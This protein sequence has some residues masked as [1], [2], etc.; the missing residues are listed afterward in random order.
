MLEYRGLKATFEHL[1]IDEAEIDRQIS[2]LIEQ[3]VRT[4]RV[5]NRPSQLDD[6]VVLDFTGEC[7]GAAFEGGHAE[8]YPLLLGS[9]TFIPGFEEQLVGRRAGD[10]VDVNV[11]FPVGYPVASLAGQKA[12]F[13]CHVRE[14]RV[15]EKYRPNDEFARE[16]GGVRSMAE[17]REKIRAELQARVDRQADRELKERLIDQLIE[18]FHPEITAGQLDA[19]LDIEMR[20]L[21]SQLASQNLTLDQYAQFT[22]RTRAQMREDRVPQARKNVWRQMA[23][24]EIV[25]REGIEAD[26]ES[27][28]DAFAA[29]CRDHGM[30][31]EQLQPYFDSQMEAALARSVVEEKALDLLRDCA[32]ITVV[33]KQA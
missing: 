2:R 18:H 25:E 4:I 17:L 14:I 12:V 1:T 9:G 20:D 31:L 10:D 6:E 5:E 30:T 23:I 32:E 11:T 8:N 15:R 33:E 28:A 24:A 29:L 7:G 16:V 26:E 27:V 22:G 13:H 3:H 21:E 19:A